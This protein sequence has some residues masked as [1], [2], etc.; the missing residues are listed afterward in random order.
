MKKFGDLLAAF[1]A[2]PGLIANIPLICRLAGRQIGEMSLTMKQQWFDMLSSKDKI[3]RIAVSMQT[4]LADHFGETLHENGTFS[5]HYRNLILLKCLEADLPDAI[6]SVLEAAPFGSFLIGRTIKR[7]T[8]E[9]TVAEEY[10]CNGVKNCRRIVRREIVKR[11]C[12]LNTWIEA[13]ACCA[14]SKC[15]KCDQYQ[16]SW[17]DYALSAENYPKNY[18]IGNNHN[19]RT[20]SGYAQLQ[21]KI[22]ML[23]HMRTGIEEVLS[24]LFP[25]VIAKLILESIIDRVITVVNSHKLSN[26]IKEEIA[27]EK[28]PHGFTIRLQDKSE[29]NDESESDDDA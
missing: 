19:W 7:F 16:H 6:H 11:G 22:F 20:S 8:H 29:P 10:L 21:N 4:G 5:T 13:S 23:Q 27:R 17:S 28:L 24:E 9:Y 26:T 15:N 12:K 14:D 1:S 2:H 3:A 25:I 18:F